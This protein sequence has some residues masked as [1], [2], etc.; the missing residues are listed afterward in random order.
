MPP[1]I[2]ELDIEN[3]VEYQPDISDPSKFG[4]NP[5]ITPSAGTLKL[6]PAIVLGDIV[7]VNRQPAKGTFVGMPWAIG[8]NP[9]PS[10]GGNIADT[11]RISIGYRTFEI[12]KSDGTP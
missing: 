12:L 10:P 9:E 2:L 8:L 3:V 6:R 11:T 5:D 7:A 4:T 1:A